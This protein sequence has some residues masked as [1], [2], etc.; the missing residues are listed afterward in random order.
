MECSLI[1][2]VHNSCTYTIFIV[3]LQWHASNST[4]DYSKEDYEIRTGLK[5]LTSDNRSVVLPIKLK[6]SYKVFQIETFWICCWSEKYPF[7]FLNFS[8]M[9]KNSNNKVNSNIYQQHVH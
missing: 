8:I 5:P 7:S 1:L 4:K 6:C 9:R 2:L 3:Y